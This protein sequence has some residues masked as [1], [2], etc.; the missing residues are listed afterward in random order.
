LGIFS[1]VLELAGDASRST[2]SPPR[3]SAHTAPLGTLGGTRR[4]GGAIGKTPK[5]AF[6]D[7]ETTGLDPKNDRIIEIAVIQT[8]S[9][10][11][12][13]D[14]WSTLVDP[15]TADAGPTWI[16]GVK[17]E[18]LAAAP[19][20]SDIVG[21]YL[22]R[23]DGRLLVAHNAA[24]DCRF[25]DAEMR[26]AGIEPPDLP[27]LDTMEICSAIGIPLKLQPACE[28]LGY[29]Y[30]AHRALDDA[31]ACGE[32]FH[33]TLQHVGPETFA[34]TPIL[35][36]ISQLA[37][38]SGL[39]CHRQEAAEQ[40]VA[41]PVLSDLMRGLPDS[42]LEGISDPIATG[43]YQELLVDALED[44]FISDDER[45]L[46]Y[47][48]ANQVSLTSQDLDKIHLDVIGNLIE[49]ALEDNK[50]S[51]KEK[52][53][54]ERAATWLGVNLDDWKVMVSAARKQVK[55]QRATFAAKWAGK[56]VAFTG[57]GDYPFNIREALALKHGITAKKSL[58]KD[59]ELLVIGSAALDTKTVQAAR[60]LDVPVMVESSFWSRLGE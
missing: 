38:P 15:G 35:N 7:I 10:G 23:L 47:Q 51:P 21:D 57:R 22:Q 19:S 56:Q 43:Q 60:K 16:H 44:G 50:I 41:R 48:L 2:S 39:T 5:L 11:R 36:G 27:R 25:L 45:Q 9:R 12:V 59:T 20:F 6:V 33:R 18:W 26:A 32:L 3:Q 24:F 34:G 40:T 28:K 37:A 42:N 4:K 29:R 1:K 14:E 58:N 8:D 52:A 49:V 54:I 53:E 55:E 13:E 30:E 46:L 17:G 31:R